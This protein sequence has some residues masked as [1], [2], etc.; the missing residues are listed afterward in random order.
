MIN[1][2]IYDSANELTGE[3]EENLRRLYQKEVNIFTCDDIDKF[4]RYIFRCRRGN[5]D[6]LFVCLR[7]NEIDEIG[8]VVKIQADYPGIQVTFVAEEE[9]DKVDIFRANPSYLIRLPLSLGR[10]QEA[11]NRMLVRLHRVRKEVVI[12]DSAEGL[13][14][15]IKDDILYVE[16]DR[17]EVR[18]YLTMD[19]KEQ[20]VAKLDQ[21]EEQLGAGFV[22]C[23]QSYLVNANRVA[24]LTG[25]EV[26]LY[27][28]AKIP[29]SR[30]RG[31]ETRMAL[32]NYLQT[33]MTMLAVL[34]DQVPINELLQ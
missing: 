28:N 23:H 13:K 31:K 29:I 25:K 3:I 32:Y 18:V 14:F 16:S 2:A 1:I 9:C 21:L 26:I 11:M 4:E 27:N 33:G 30:N 24:S 5:V 22:R 17:K 8:H 7:E 10:I 34:V 12:F 19:R 20:G 6:I 15:L